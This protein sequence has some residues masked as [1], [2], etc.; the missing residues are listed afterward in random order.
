MS[1]KTY[2]AFDVADYVVRYAYENGTPVTNL[3]LNKILFLIW[4]DY[5]RDTGKY[6]FRHP[7]FA[8]LRGPV[9]LDVYNRYSHYGGMP[10]NPYSGKKNEELN[11]LAPYIDEYRFLN[12]DELI[13]LTTK[14][15][16]AWDEVWKKESA[17]GRCDRGFIGF[18]LMIGKRK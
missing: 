10:I 8:W 6:L 11:C 13:S 9:Q 16:G 3:S 1:D 12:Q 17:Q 4:I 18:D 14:E 2:S 7:F 5:Y 15:G